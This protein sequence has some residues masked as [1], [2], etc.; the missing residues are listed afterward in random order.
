[1][2]NL[3]RDTKVNIIFLYVQSNLIL[4]DYSKCETSTYFGTD[5]VD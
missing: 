2:A 5:G 3:F 4:V 1:M